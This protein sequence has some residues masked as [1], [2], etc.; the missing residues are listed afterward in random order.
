MQ[1]STDGYF[2]SAARAIE[3]KNETMD[4]QYQI[5]EHCFSSMAICAAGTALQVARES[6]PQNGGATQE[7]YGPG[8]STLPPPPN[9]NPDP[10]SIL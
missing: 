7:E 8:D 2:L 5:V 3:R 4:V 10:S 6:A 1:S 9:P